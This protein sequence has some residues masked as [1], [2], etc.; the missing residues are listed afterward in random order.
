MLTRFEVTN[1]K[2]FKD[3]LVLDFSDTRQYAFNP[4]CVVNGVVNKALI[5]GP[6][7][8]GK[9]NLGYAIVDLVR[10]LT[11]T[12]KTAHGVYLNCYTNAN[13]VDEC[14]QFKYSFIF[15]NSSVVFEYKKNDLSYILHERLYINNK[16]MVEYY[17]GRPFSSVLSG[18]ET[19]HADLGGSQ[20]S[21]LKYIRR[22]AVL[23]GN[24]DN[25]LF[26]E[27][28]NFVEKMLF[29]GSLDQNMFIGYD[30]TPF[31]I[32]EDILD[33]GHLPEFNEFLNRAGVA[34]D[35]DVAPSSY[36]NKDIVFKFKNKSIPFYDIASN[37]TKALA[38]FYAWY[39]RLQL[40]NEISFVFI[41]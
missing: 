7:G 37:G 40:A 35:L 24:E 21:V 23:T 36:S 16:L 22:N 17:F 2:Q 1:F 14:A 29:F 13:S 31:T 9:S 18:T 19:L 27:F 10:H 39:Q 12:D 25:R 11:D 26:N 32:L 20:I 8:C 38:L 6:N 34:C 30:N 3:T 28:F 4:E 15:N 5:Y 33:K 41:A